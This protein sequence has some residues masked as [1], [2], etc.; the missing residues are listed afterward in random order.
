MTPEIRASLQNDFARSRVLWEKIVKYSFVANGTALGISVGALSKISGQQPLAQIGKFPLIVFFCGLLLSGFHLLF[1]YVSQLGSIRQTLDV[2]VGELTAEIERTRGQTKDGG[3]I[4]PD[5][6]KLTRD[7]ERLN[8]AISQINE[9]EKPH[10]LK[11]YRQVEEALLFASYGC[12]LVG[13]L[14]VIWRI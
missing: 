10:D 9:E 12:F 4:S 7:L 3:L 1:A 2:Q 13:V 14:V 11:L 8:T 5:I 6:S